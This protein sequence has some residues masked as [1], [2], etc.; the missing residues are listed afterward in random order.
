MY[1]FWNNYIQEC[2]LQFFPYS[3]LYVQQFTLNKTG[4]SKVGATSK[5]QKVQSFQNCKR[6]G[7]FFGFLKVQFYAK[8]QNYWTTI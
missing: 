7:G 6:G 8:Y 1:P 5:A 4:M 3:W 2:E